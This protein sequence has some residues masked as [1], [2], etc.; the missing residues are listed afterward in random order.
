MGTVILTLLVIGEIIFLLWSFKAGSIKRREKYI[1]KIVFAVLLT[2]LLIAGIL[3]GVSRYGAILLVLLFQACIGL[4]AEYRDKGKSY[5][6]GKRIA[7]FLGN[8]TV[9]FLALVP[10]F[11]FP[12]YKPLPVT[13]GHTVENAEY[14]YV[15]ENRIETFSDIGENRSVTVKFWYPAETGTYPLVV[16]S[17][18]AFGVIDSNN[19][20]YTELASHGYVVASIGHPY[21]AMFVTDVNGKTTYASKKFI[22]QI[23]DM[24]SDETPDKKETDYLKT[25]YLKTREWMKVRTEDMNFVLDTILNKADAANEAPFSLIDGDKIGLF[26]HSLGGATSVQV[27]RERKDIDAVIDLEGTMLGEYIGIENGREIYNQE[28]YPIP[29][30]DMNSKAVHAL[31]LEVPGDGYVNFYMG[32]RALDYREVIFDNAGHLNFTDLP[33]VS[34]PLAGLLG[35]GTVDARE[36]IENVNYVVLTFFNYYLKGEGTLAIEEEY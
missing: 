21:H 10:A 5:G 7:L 33:L 32:E 28:P 1:W 29:L 8:I 9:Y 18:G 26:G 35:V 22:E 17:H 30:L 34:P 4:L 3:E 25:D 23:Y 31:A 16:F 15:D 36:C 27:G 14:T 12:Q 19:S 6:K 20:T 2:L 24:N 13:G 11:F